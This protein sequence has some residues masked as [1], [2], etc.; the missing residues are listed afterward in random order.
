MAGL[1]LA[2]TGCGDSGAVAASDARADAAASVSSA[3]AALTGQS[4]LPSTVITVDVGRVDDCTTLAWTLTPMLSS[5]GDLSAEEVNQL[6]QS[7]ITEIGSYLDAI[8]AR[9]KALACDDAGWKVA[10]CDA[11]LAAETS[12]A[13][14]MAVQFCSAGSPTAGTAST[15]SIAPAPTASSAT[16]AVG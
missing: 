15:S 3:V 2:G 11:M 10:R 8:E 12:M 7:V 4:G 5:L 14:Q 16:N 6:D 9:R 13:A 1:C